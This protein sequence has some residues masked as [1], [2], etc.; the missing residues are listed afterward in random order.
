MDTFVES[1]WYFERYCSPGFNTGMFE[2]G[3]V[4]A[5]FNAVEDMRTPAPRGGFVR[6]LIQRLFK[7]DGVHKLQGFR[8]F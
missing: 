1:S 4:D 5:P 3:A 6:G 7:G 8:V 2:K